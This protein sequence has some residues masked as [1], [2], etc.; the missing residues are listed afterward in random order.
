METKEATLAL[1]ES[2]FTLKSTNPVYCLIAI[3][4]AAASGDIAAAEEA[5]ADLKHKFKTDVFKGLTPVEKAMA[6][7]FA[8]RLSTGHFSE[9]LELGAAIRNW[10]YEDESTK[11]CPA[12]ALLWFGLIR[13]EMNLPHNETA[14]IL[15]DYEGH[16]WLLRKYG[17]AEGPPVE[18][19]WALVP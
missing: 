5:F 1:T 4:I 7:Y 12:E 19:D 17:R 14:A 2:K 8:F 10:L 15:T 9:K 3:L 11:N 6:S 16:G 18:G 13:R